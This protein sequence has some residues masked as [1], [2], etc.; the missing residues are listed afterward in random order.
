[1]APHFDPDS[2]DRRMS[3]EG[4]ALLRA[5]AERRFPA[6]A[7]RPFTEFRVC[8]YENSL[9]RR[10]PHRPPSHVENVFL[11]GGGSGHGFKHGPEVGRMMAELV[12]EGKAPDARFS[13]ASKGNVQAREVL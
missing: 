9:Q 4:A 11:L 6:L 8:Q 13:L 2:G 3:E 7:G 10:F 1:M 12:L 5:F